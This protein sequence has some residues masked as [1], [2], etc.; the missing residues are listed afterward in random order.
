MCHFEMQDRRRLYGGQVTKAFDRYHDFSV[1][2]K[3]GI[4]M[5]TPR[6]LRYCIRFLSFLFFPSSPSVH[7]TRLGVAITRYVFVWPREHKDGAD[8]EHSEGLMEPVADEDGDLEIAGRS[9]RRV[10]SGTRVI[11][12]GHSLSSPLPLVGLQ[13]WSGALLL[14]DYLFHVHQKIMNKT[15]LEVGAGTGLCSI[16]A[17]L[18][19]ERIL[20]TDFSDH[21]LRQCQKNFERNEQLVSQFRRGRRRPSLLFRRLDLTAE[22]PFGHGG[23]SS[24]EWTWTAADSEAISETRVLLASDVIYENRLTDG[25]FSFL[26]RM[27]RDGPRWELFLTLERRLNFTLENLEVGCPAHDHF[28]RQLEALKRSERTSV[29]R[30][31][32]DFPRHFDYRRTDYLELWRISCK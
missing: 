8:E 25:F 27:L 17:S 19:A 10:A 3:Q 6:R 7:S 2:G 16:V 31:T 20:C 18:F 22:D 28:L 14:C 4:C 15:V 9:A 1:Q 21:V 26:R 32:T 13:I 11:V 12:V 29:E 5:V 30:L 23:P 24:D